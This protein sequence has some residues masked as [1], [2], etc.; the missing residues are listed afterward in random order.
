MRELE[1]RLCDVF[2]DTPFQGNQLAVFDDAGELTSDEMQKLAGETNLSET[3]FIIRRSPEIEH[4]RGVRVRIFTTAEELPFAGHPTLGTSACIRQHLPEYAD[5]ELITL[6]LNVGAVSVRFSPTQREPAVYGEMTQPDPVFGQTHDPAAIAPA[7]GL[8]PRDLAAEMP[9]Q[10]VSTG[11]PYCIVPLRSLDALSRLRIPQ[12]NAGEYLRQTDAK[13][14]YCISPES[15][16]VWRARM[17]FYNGE[18]PATGSAA[19]CAI[20]W[21]VRH[22]FASSD[23]QLQIRQGIEMG[24]PSTVEVRAKFDGGSVREVRVGGSTVFVAKGRFFLE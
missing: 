8:D 5:R 6:E 12:A 19:G 4:Q 24:R 20:S 16:N 17:Q 18:D 9:L 22:G 13:F 1:Y 21:L 2:T 23:Q 11:L 7:I 10:T 3:T 15:K 14:F